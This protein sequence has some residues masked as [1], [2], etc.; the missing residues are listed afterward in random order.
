[1][2]LSIQS[3]HDRLA[4][5]N[6]TRR[7]RPAT[8]QPIFTP[9]NGPKL[10][11]RY[12]ERRLRPWRP[13]CWS[14]S[15]GRTS[16][17]AADRAP[18]PPRACCMAGSRPRPAPS[19]AG[20]PAMNS[21]SAHVEARRRVVAARACP[22]LI[23]RINPYFEPRAYVE[24]LGARLKTITHVHRVVRRLRVD[25]QSAGARLSGGAAARKIRKAE[26]SGIQRARGQTRRGDWTDYV[27][28][29][30]ASLERW[31]DAAVDPAVHG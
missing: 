23:W 21:R 1:M 25:R 30:E 12:S 4:A 9:A 3:S 20:S 26:R 29:Y 28:C 19:A 6:G 13:A 14:F 11:E 2:S 27:A 16:A 31:G 5:A 7:G 8:T 18:R 24:A 10:W 15:D 17:P 22:D